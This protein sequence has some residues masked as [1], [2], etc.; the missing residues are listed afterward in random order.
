MIS[1]RKGF[2]SWALIQE[3]SVPGRTSITRAQSRWSLEANIG[4]FDGWLENT[5]TSS[6]DCPCKAGL[7]R[8]I[9]R[10][11]RAL[12][13]TRLFGRGKSGNRSRAKAGRYEID[14]EK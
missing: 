6:C 12:C 11:L 13:F 1:K 10:W 9:F 8:S 7:L 14:C 2:G 3:P 5:A 4:A